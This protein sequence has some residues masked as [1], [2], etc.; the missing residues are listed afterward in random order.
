M[1]DIE[2]N[3]SA[4]GPF[5]VSPEALN[6]VNEVRRYASLGAR[7]SREAPRGRRATAARLPPAAPLLAPFAAQGCRGLAEAGRRRRRRVGAA[8]V[9]A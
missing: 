7:A 5:H 8:R 6:E 9:A 2:K 3:V 4:A 1:G